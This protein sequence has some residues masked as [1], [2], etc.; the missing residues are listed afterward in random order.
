MQPPVPFRNITHGGEQ[1]MITKMRLLGATLLVAS[2]CG[3]SGGAFAQGPMAGP[4]APGGI[5]ALLAGTAVS[6]HVLGRQAARGLPTDIYGSVQGNTNTG[7]GGG[8]ITNTNAI[9]NNTGI[10]TI[11]QN[12]GNNSLFQNQTVVNVSIH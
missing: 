2:L 12:T 4:A 3:V 6:N 10:T 9:D 5:A 8:T 7:G 1:R 11:F